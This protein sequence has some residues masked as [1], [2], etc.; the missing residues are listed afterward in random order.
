MEYPS[1]DWLIRIPFYI[2]FGLLTEIFYTGIADLVYPRYLSSWHAK[3]F[4]DTAPAIPRRD[5]RAM[6]YTFLWMIPIYA[7]LVLVEPLYNLMQGAP[8]FVR[9][10]V[11]MMAIWIGEYMTGAAIKKTFGV[12]PWDYSYS[13]FSLHGYIRWDFGPFWYFWSFLLEWYSH[14]L[15]LITPSLRQVF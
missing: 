3:G 13:R 5:S 1:P 4:A 9:G 2:A 14:K 8:L 15:V 7:T 11:Y 12:C 10:F 6:G